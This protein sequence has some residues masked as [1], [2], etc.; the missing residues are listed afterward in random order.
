[1]GWQA[2]RSWAIMSLFNPAPALTGLAC[3]AALLGGLSIF[4]S[5]MLVKNAALESYL[6]YVSH[7]FDALVKP[8]NREAVKANNGQVKAAKWWQCRFFW[9]YE[10]QT[11][12]YQENHS[13]KE[14]AASELAPAQNHNEIEEKSKTSSSYIAKTGS[15]T[16]LPIR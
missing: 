4:G 3:G 16:A 11:A 1:M 14:T 10:T 2:L 8:D 12:H 15:T 7:I 6:D 9:G 5:Y 13:Y